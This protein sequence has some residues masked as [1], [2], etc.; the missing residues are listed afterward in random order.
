MQV[1]A[2]C[3]E[4]VLAGRRINFEGLAFASET[5]LR[6][7]T[8]ILP[9]A[10]LVYL[11]HQITRNFG[12]KKNQIILLKSPVQTPVSLTMLCFDALG[13]ET[14]EASRINSRRVKSGKSELLCYYQLTACNGP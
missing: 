8:R 13:G 1:L 7:K 5:I 2:I 6:Q 12:E 9:L 14:A 3:S 11:F 4:Q 10:D